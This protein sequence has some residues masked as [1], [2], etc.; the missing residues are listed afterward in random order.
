MDD[1]KSQTIWTRANQKIAYP[2]WY[3]RKN[4]QL[5]RI[6]RSARVYNIMSKIRKN[7]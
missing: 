5:P 4:P 2:T 3:D 7:I 1:Q 6:G